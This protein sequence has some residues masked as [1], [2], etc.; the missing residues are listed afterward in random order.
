MRQLLAD[1][2]EDLR[3]DVQRLRAEVE[4]TAIYHENKEDMVFAA[5]P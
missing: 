3:A 1:T 4:M 2:K 5:S